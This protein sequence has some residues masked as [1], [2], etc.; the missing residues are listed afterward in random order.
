MQEFEHLLNS[1]PLP[2]KYIVIP[3]PNDPPIN[4]AKKLKL[5]VNKVITELSKDAFIHCGFEET[6]NELKWN[7]SWG[8][9]FV[10][11]QYRSC[12]SWQKVNH[13]AGAFFMGRKDFF[14]KRMME[15]KD[16]IGE[17]ANFYPESYIYPNELDKLTQHYHDHRLWIIKPSASSRGRGIHVV[18]STKTE[19]PSDNEE[20]IVQ[21]YI[22]HPFLIKG[23]KFDIRMYA[24]ITSASPIRIYLH[25]SGLIR[26]ATHQY[27][28]NADP[29][30]AKTHLTNFALNKDDPDFVRCDDETGESVDDSKWSIPFFK[31]YLQENGFDC[32]KIFQK[33]ED[34]ATK[35]LLAG[36]STIQSHHSRQ[37]Q[38]RHTSYEQYGLDL[39]L[40]EQFNVYVMEV[41][42]SPGMSGSDSKLDFDI[43]NRLMHNLLDM[44]RIVDCDCE[45]K[46]ACPGIDEVDRQ[47]RLSVTNARTRAVRMNQIKA[48]DSPVF[49]DYTMIRDFIE[50]QSRLGG[51]KMT[52]P[53]RETVD[54]YLPCIGDLKYHDIVFIEWIKMND[55]ERKAAI[56]KNLDQYR[57][58]LDKINQAQAPQVMDDDEDEM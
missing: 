32:D 51:Y 19:L 27:D 24:L 13:F 31:K 1:I 44:A 53:N 5:Y 30:D 52:F 28:P 7:V 45:L 2:Y 18:D 57:E 33:L 29:S 4:R 3:G 47:C 46:D 17:Q 48:W 50:E 25:D 55:Q 16:R 54:S 9:Q 8:R 56:E 38:H 35:T 11:N 22:E 39:L 41:N 26:F 23:R 42:V 15:L 12:K 6:T 14:H 10:I 49:A 34:A 20:A 43:K 40:D 36:M 58:I 21:Y 37:V